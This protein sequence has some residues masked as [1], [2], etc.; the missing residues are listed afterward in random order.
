MQIFKWVFVAMSLVLFTTVGANAAD[1]SSTSKEAAGNAKTAAKQAPGRKFAK[2][3]LGMTLKQVVTAIG[4]PT[5]QWTHPTGK[6]AI[7]FYFGPDR[8]AIE[9]SYAG[10]GLLT[11]NSGGDQVLT[12]IQVNR[13]EGK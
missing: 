2:L 11:F 9:Y 8:W 6:S 10:E 7:P 13:S 1:K 4:E 12:N 3:K 5:K